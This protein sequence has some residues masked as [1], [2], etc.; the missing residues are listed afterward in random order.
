VTDDED[1]GEGRQARLPEPAPDSWEAAV[2]V[3]VAAQ[4]DIRA[5]AADVEYLSAIA[6]DLVG[7]EGTVHRIDGLV[8]ELA[9]VSA[10]QAAQLEELTVSKRRLTVPCLE[11][12]EPAEYAEAL[13]GLGEWVHTILVPTY[14]TGRQMRADLSVR[15]NSQ[16]LSSCWYRHPAAVVELVWLQVAWMAAY[17]TRGARWEEAANFHD[18]WMNAMGRIRVILAGCEGPQGHAAGSV[19]EASAHPAATPEARTEFRH[20]L[21]D[22]TRAAPASG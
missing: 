7:P 20:Y 4:R 16:G 11:D 8:A 5:L 22:L 1:P 9:R 19:I 17:R 2:E 21:R 6:E 15:G 10:D 13:R 18:R 12:L 14:L 3:L